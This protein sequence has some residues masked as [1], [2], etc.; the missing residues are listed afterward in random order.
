MSSVT[1]SEDRT[2]RPLPVTGLVGAAWCV[3]LGLAV[4]TTITLI[5]W[6]AAPRTALGPGLPGV[7]RTAVTFWLVAHHAGFSVSGGR[8]GLLPLGLTVLPGALLYRSGGWMIRASGLPRRP[9]MGVVHVA[10]ALAFPYTVL[11][12][13]LALVV[14][15][16]VIQPSLWQALI[17]C[18]LLAFAAGGMGAARALVAARGRRVRSGLGAMLRLL[19]ERPRSVVTGVLAAISVLLA[20]GAI[21]VGASLAVHA[22]DAKSTYDILAPGIIGGLLL[23]LVEVVYLPNAVIFGMAYAIGPGFSVGAGT[24]VSPTGVFLGAIPSFPPL[25]ALPQQGPAPALSLIALAAPFVAGAVGGTLTIRAMPS[26]VYE[27]APLWGFVTGVLTG[28]VTAVLAALAGGPMGGGRMVT[29]GPS[30]WQ[31]GLM[32]ALEVGVA[33]AIAAWVTNWRLLRAPSPEVVAERA[34]RKAAAKAAKAAKAEAKPAEAEPVPA[35]AVDV[36]WT[37]EP[38]EFVEPEPMLAPRR[39]ARTAPEIETEDPWESEPPKP[40]PASEPQEGAKIYQ[41]RPDD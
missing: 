21:L 5:G 18:F 23:L 14:R 33:A 31:V 29:I 20:S 25:A 30:P 13:L 40:R 26:P 37:E 35:P 10:L 27:A 2:S 41:F 16:S 9:R 34:A 6:M 4:L 3:G 11:A 19:P 36:V 12:G 1:E 38:V 7:F 39:P 15:T 32:A 22:G 17:V 24:S 28:A 8:V